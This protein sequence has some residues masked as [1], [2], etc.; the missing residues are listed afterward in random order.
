MNNS[1]IKI[2]DWNPWHG[3]HKLGEGCRYCWVFE[4]DRKYNR[5]TEHIVTNSSQYRL[6][7]K[8]NLSNHTRKN[9][10][11]YKVPG[12]SIIN[13]CTTSDFFIEDADPFRY[14]ALSFINE[15]TDCLF[16]IHTRRPFNIDTAITDA[17]QIIPW[18]D[19]FWKHVMIGVS[20]ENQ[21]SADELIPYVLGL[22]YIEHI[23][24]LLSPLLED[25]D[26]RPYLSSG[27]IDQ[28]LLRGETYSGCKGLARPLSISTVKDIAEQCYE[29]ETTFYFNR[30]GSWFEG[31]DKKKF[32]VHS[33][34]ERG[35]ADFYALG[36]ESKFF[37]IETLVNKI[38]ND[39]FIIRAENINSY[40]KG[41]QI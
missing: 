28:V 18:D 15:R 10:S 30:T 3:C 32:Y 38:Y 31:P 5:N 19:Y 16:R 25:I 11:D 9:D 37:N 24:L 22:D 33:K 34:D 27:R 2:Y 17:K 21:E 20:V 14:N 13:V 41:R 1:N 39:Y 4:E 7:V 23:E 26:I 6:P 36:Y 35:M 29:Y 12:R 40:I 8:L